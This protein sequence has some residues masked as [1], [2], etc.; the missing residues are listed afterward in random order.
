MG[1]GAGN[2]ETE[3]FIAINDETRSKVRGYDLNYFLEDINN[4][5]KKL[6][7]GSSFAYA[8]ASK[9]GYSQAEMMNLLQKKRLDP[10]SALEQISQSKEHKI[11][12]KIYDLKKFFKKIK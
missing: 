6:N 5:K 1:R 8:F 7:W 3:L 4:L 9:N 12:F 2:A 10:S 11:I